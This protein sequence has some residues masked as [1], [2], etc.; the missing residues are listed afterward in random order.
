MTFKNIAGA[1][2]ISLG[3]VVSINSPAFAESAVS[4][5][6]QSTMIERRGS[7]PYLHKST[8]GTL[9]GTC[10][11]RVDRPHK[12]YTTAYQ[13]HTRAESFCQDLPMQT[14]KISGKTFRSRWYG[15]ENM[16]SASDGPNT[17]NPLRITV[18]VGVGPGDVHKW[19]TEAT[20]IAVI[21]GKPRTASA[22]ELSDGEIHF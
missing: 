2:L 7:A 20:G 8:A 14:N 3:M 10:G 16:A 22:Y 13:V 5:H 11:V 21:D 12:S 15:W 1:G 18:V 9:A 19:R 4:E 17:K 6:D